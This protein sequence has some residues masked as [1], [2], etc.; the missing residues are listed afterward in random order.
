M[1]HKEVATR[2]QSPGERLSVIRDDP[3]QEQRSNSVLSWGN[4]LPKETYFC[5]YHLRAGCSI[6]GAAGAYWGAPRPE[7]LC[8]GEGLAQRGCWQWVIRISWR[9]WQGMQKNTSLHLLMPWLAPAWGMMGKLTFL[10][11]PLGA[12]VTFRGAGAVE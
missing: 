5:T 7:A 10:S 6:T 4:K 12:M 2:T 9:Q 8:W 3:G 1:G 11:A